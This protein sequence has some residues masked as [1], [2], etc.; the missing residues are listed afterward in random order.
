MLNQL[1]IEDPL[2]QAILSED[3]ALVDVPGGDMKF[4]AIVNGSAHFLGTFDDPAA[5][6]AALDSLDGRA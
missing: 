4:Y 1:R 6:L 5:A 2:E 3:S